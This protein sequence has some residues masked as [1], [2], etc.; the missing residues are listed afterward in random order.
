M[1]TVADRSV[2]RAA[3]ND[4]CDLATAAYEQ[5]E[6]DYGSRCAKASIVSPKDTVPKVSAALET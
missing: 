5:A 1:P 2:S 4:A 6:L 3:E